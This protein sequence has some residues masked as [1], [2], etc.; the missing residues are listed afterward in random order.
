MSCGATAGHR[1]F[2]G[3]RVIVL[4][5]MVIL[6]DRLLRQP[7]TTTTS[8]AVAG[9]MDDEH[10]EETRFLV[11]WEVYAKQSETFLPLKLRQK[12]GEGL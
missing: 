5:T 6:M 1:G 2:D 3:T 8:K 9:R 10:E 11:S 4:G 7:L 12:L